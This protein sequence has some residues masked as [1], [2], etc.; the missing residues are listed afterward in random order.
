VTSTGEIK[1][2]IAIGLLFYERI[3]L[4]FG[5]I[6]KKDDIIGV[7]MIFILKIIIF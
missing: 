2:M 6:K 1:I 4:S 5:N 3:K 7:R